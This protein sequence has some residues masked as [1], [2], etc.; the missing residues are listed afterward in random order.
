M[1]SLPLSTGQQLKLKTAGF[2]VAE[3]LKDISVAELSK[4][5][6]DAIFLFNA[7]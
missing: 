7:H 5:R 1:T 3:D 6:G 4:G 2:D